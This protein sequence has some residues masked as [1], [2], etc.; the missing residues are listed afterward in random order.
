M[1]LRKIILQLEEE[2]N[3]L[4]DKTKNSKTIINSTEKYP[5]NAN[6]LLQNIEIIGLSYQFPWQ[7]IGDQDVNLKF[8]AYNFA[9]FGQMEQLR[10]VCYFFYPHINFYFD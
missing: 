5:Y 9:R 7:F 2:I 6:F 8:N 1:L 3:K 10:V 4:K